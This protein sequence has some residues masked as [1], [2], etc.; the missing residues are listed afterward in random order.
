M[1]TRDLTLLAITASFSLT[2]IINHPAVTLARYLIQIPF[3]YYL[4]KEAFKTLLA[5]EA[6]I[7]MIQGITQFNAVYTWTIVLFPIFNPL[8]TLRAAEELLN[9]YNLTLSE[10]A[11][12]IIIIQIMI[13]ICVSVMIL[14]ILKH[15]SRKLMVRWKLAQRI[16]HL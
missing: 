1:K 3:L 14:V 4:G 15:L 13:N 5:I 7:N 16:G 9:I 12:T 2:R 11:T 8:K 6:L 10:L